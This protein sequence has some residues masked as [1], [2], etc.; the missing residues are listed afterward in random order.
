MCYRKDL[1]QQAGLPADREQV[2]Q[3][4][5]TWDQYLDVARQYKTATGKPFVDSPASI[6]SSSV[7]QGDEAYN[8]ETATRSPRRA[9][10]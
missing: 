1:F 10:G 4:W 3:L 6:F 5:P 7:Y 2:G 9:P 8:D